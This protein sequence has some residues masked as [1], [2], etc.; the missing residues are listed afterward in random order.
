MFLKDTDDNW[1]CSGH[2]SHL[3]IF[4]HDLL[5]ATL[6]EIGKVRLQKDSESVNVC[7]THGWKANV[8]FAFLS[9]HFGPFSA[10]FRVTFWVV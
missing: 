5:D 6:V 9:R 4:L 8:V 7:V 2:S 1:N 3:C 10:R